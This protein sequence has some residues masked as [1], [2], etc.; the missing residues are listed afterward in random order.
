MQNGAQHNEKLRV[1]FQQPNNSKSYKSNFNY[2]YQPRNRAQEL[3]KNFQTHILQLLLQ[4]W[5]YL[6]RM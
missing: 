3:K 1:I 2:T 6:I 5:S 4:P